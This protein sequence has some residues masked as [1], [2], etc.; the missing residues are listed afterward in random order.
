MLYVI[1]TRQC[2]NCAKY[3]NEP[4]LQFNY[5]FTTIAMSQAQHE[6]HQFTEEHHITVDESSS[7]TSPVV[8]DHFSSTPVT[9]SEHYTEPQ[10][11]NISVSM[12]EVN[13]TPVPL[14][15]IRTVVTST[16]S[17]HLNISLNTS[18]GATTP[19]PI[20]SSNTVTTS[21][22]SAQYTTKTNVP[23]YIYVSTQQFSST[24]ATT[25]STEPISSVS[26]ASQYQ[27]SETNELNLVQLRFRGLVNNIQHSITWAI[28]Y[29]RH[30][31]PHSALTQLHS[32]SSSS[33][34]CAFSAPPTIRPMT[35][36][37]KN[38]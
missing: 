27:I 19:V 22:S 33:S 35:Q 18:Q 9:Y 16:T 3:W 14:P 2:Q 5:Q 28:T 13:T 11:L 1:Q 7:E 20:Q 37:N 38:L 24:T 12:S 34:T 17:S 32:S 15:P 21:A 31:D 30:N 36:N 25:T 26:S 29:L 6:D 4:I 8:I 23:K 10:Q